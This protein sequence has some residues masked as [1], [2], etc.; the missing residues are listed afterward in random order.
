MVAGGLRPATASGAG[1]ASVASRDAPGGSSAA[2][3]LADQLVAHVEQVA[4]GRRRRVRS[5]LK[6]RRRRTKAAAWPTA[7]GSRAAGRRT[8]RV[9]RT[10]SD[11]RV[12]PRVTAS[13]RARATVNGPVASSVGRA[14]RLGMTRGSSGSLAA[15]WQWL[16]LWTRAPGRGWLWTTRT[17][18]S[19][20]LGIPREHPWQVRDAGGRSRASATA[21]GHPSWAH[22]RARPSRR[23]PPAYSAHAS[24]HPHRPGARRR[25]HGGAGPA[26]PRRQRHGE[27]VPP[28]RRGSGHHPAGG[29]AVGGVVRARG[30]RRHRAER[31]PGAGGPGRRGGRGVVTAGRRPRHRRVRGARRA[32]RRAL[33]RHHPGCRAPH[34]RRVA[35]GQRPGRR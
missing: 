1:Q 2:R 28:V 11:P 8:P 23:R 19:E 21:A 4:P 17:P 16:L 31:R 24:R 30:S 15:R 29:R 35:R 13:R 34:H 5:E 18:V 3:R 25:R 10:R 20:P 12:R 7:S 32:D 27:L 9:G 33:L 14:V 26:L 6:A 22:R